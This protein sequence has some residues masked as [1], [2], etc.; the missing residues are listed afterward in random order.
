METITPIPVLLITFNR[1]EHTKKTIA[2]LRIQ[3]PPL[4]FVFQDGPR[5]GNMKDVEDC[6]SVREIVKLG[7]DW[8]CERH[9]YFSEFNRGCRDAV[10][11]AITEVLK[12]Y[13]SVIVIEDDIITSPAFYKYMC[14]CLNHY[15]D[16]KSVFSISG[17]S[18]SP[19]KF[20]VPK[21]YPYDVF[22][23]PRLFNWGWGTWRDRWEQTDWSM[24]YFDALMNNPFEQQAFNRGGDDMMTMLVDEKEGR[25]SAWDIQF[26]YAHFRNHA[27]SIVPC[28]SYTNNIGLDGSGTHC[29]Q[30][31]II[32]NNAIVLNQ[33]DNPKLLDNLYFDSRILNLMYSAF[34]RKKRPI[35]KKAI[36]YA[37]R[38]LG[39]NP[40][41][42]IKKKIYA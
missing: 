37:A 13:D 21:D 40:P 27:V 7:I 2:S 25:S 8:N 24:A 34:S 3:E 41:F 33:N 9:F 10:I 35:W 5:L 38:K 18:H 4:V 20:R 32:R 11:F 1:P 42:V 17:H 28:V 6:S 29:Q 39:Y 14:K 15:K 30:S 19:V 22:A 16:R 23:S 26:T 31:R 12:Q 36:N